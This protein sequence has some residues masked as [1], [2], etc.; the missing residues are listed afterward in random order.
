MRVGFFQFSPRFGEV[1]QNI[2]FIQKRLD[3]VNADLVVLPEL[4]ATGYQFKSKKEV[5]EL[6]EKIPDGKTTRRLE[7]IAR[8]RKLWI[9]GG[10]PERKGKRLFNSAV[11]IGPKGY[12]GTYRKI[13][14]FDEEKKWFTPGGEGFRVFRVGKVRVGMMICFDWIF[15]E[16]ARSLALY[17]WVIGAVCPE[18]GHAEGLLSPQLNTKIINTFLEQFSETVPDSEH[19]VM[20]WDGAGFHTARTLKVPE[21][22]TLVQLPPYSP[23]LNPI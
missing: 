13:H 21:N 9:V 18:T 1:D 4:F 14:L 3:K 5:A 15:P 7:E 8:K 2:N 22:I 10:L 16:S 17:L 11:L 20:I 12:A 6:S 23:E 19:A